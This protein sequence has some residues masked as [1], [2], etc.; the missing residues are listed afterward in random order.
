[1]FNAAAAGAGPAFLNAWGG[2]LAYTFQIYFD[3]SG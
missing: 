2:A 1:V 3:F